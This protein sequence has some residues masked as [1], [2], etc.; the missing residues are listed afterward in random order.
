MQT[1]ETISLSAEAAEKAR[2]FMA[3]EKLTPESAGLRVAVLPGGCSGFQYG[4]SIEEA[5]R[6]DD[7]VIE[8]HGIRIF[9]DPFSSQYLKGTV[10]GYHSSFQGS[11]FTFSNPNA[12]GGCGCGSS[13]AV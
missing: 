13:F 3:A 10:I 11:G 7:A 2:E 5:A 8:S 12:A 1:V 9:V 4:L 6:A